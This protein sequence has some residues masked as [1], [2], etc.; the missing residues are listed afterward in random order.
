MSTPAHQ[1]SEIALAIEHYLRQHP[2]A[3]DTV[4]GIRMW[5]LPIDW[6]VDINDVEAALNELKEQGRIRRQINT[7]NHVLF[8]ASRDQPKRNH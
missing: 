8:C 4:E 5:W 7:D 1:R 2:N 6:Q 3:S